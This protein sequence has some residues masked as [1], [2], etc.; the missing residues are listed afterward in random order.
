MEDT[1]KRTKQTIENYKKAVKYLDKL[2]VFDF[3]SLKET[4][5][6]AGSEAQESQL[7]EMWSDAK[8]VLPGPGNL[9][10]TQSLRKITRDSFTE[11]IDKFQELVNMMEKL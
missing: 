5:R 3:D 2:E 10:G 7:R 11:A 9:G 8:L 4:H 6:I 1:V